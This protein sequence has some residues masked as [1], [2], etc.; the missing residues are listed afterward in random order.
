MKMK[1]D[2]TQEEELKRF[3]DKLFKKYPDLK[4]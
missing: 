3:N 2:K 1:T 4:K